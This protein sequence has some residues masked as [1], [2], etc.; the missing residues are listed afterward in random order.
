MA[1]FYYTSRLLFNLKYNNGILKIL[2][3]LFHFNVVFFLR[4]KPWKSF[5]SVE[6]TFHIF[7]L[8]RR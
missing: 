4:N 2:R 1:P 7:G 8:D 3:F 5:Q 6:F